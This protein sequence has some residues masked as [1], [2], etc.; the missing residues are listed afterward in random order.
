MKEGRTLDLSNGIRVTPLAVSS[1]P[2][3]GNGIVGVASGS[4]DQHSTTQPPPSNSTS[5]VHRLSGDLDLLVIGTSITPRPDHR[6]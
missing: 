4:G 6:Q 1:S 5:N 3:S 2:P